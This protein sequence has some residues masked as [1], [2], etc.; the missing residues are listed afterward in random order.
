[1]TDMGWQGIAD[2]LQRI[3]SALE[4]LDCRPRPA[5]RGG[6]ES[7]PAQSP[8]TD[9]GKTLDGCPKSRLQ[10]GAGVASGPREYKSGGGLGP[11]TLAVEVSAS[12][13]AIRR[14]GP[15]YKCPVCEARKIAARLR[16]ARHRAKKEAKAK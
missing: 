1:M 14:G 6:G 3:A 12:P 5:M 4:A 8:L 15:D 13:S 9:R 11:S 16:V 2:S 10:L 7:R